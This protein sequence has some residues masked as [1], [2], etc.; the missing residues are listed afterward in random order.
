MELFECHYC[1]I[2]FIDHVRGKYMLDDIFDDV[3]DEIRAS[4][5]KRGR[6]SNPNFTQLDS[7]EAKSKANEANTNILF[8]RQKVDKLMLITEAMWSILKET[9]K[10]TDEELKERMRQLEL[11]DDKLDVKASKCS[12]CGKILQK[13]MPSCIYCGTQ[14]EQEVFSR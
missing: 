5:Y 2:M 12:K 6:Y 8:L 4:E 3:L 7:I 9:T 10:C 11:K 13:N 14:N 1:K